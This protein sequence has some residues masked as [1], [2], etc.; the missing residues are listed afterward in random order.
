MKPLLYVLL[1]ALIS[2]NASGATADSCAQLKNE[3]KSMQKAQASVMS[4][5]VNNHET[6]ASSLEEYS[7]TLQEKPATAKHVGV[8]MN[9]SAHAF[10]RRGVQGKQMAQQLNA[11]TADLLARVSECL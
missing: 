7:S 6:F 2:L 5:L 10:R 1:T 4:S 3:L 11:A 9:K 8:Q